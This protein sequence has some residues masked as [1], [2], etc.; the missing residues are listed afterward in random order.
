M[1]ASRPNTHTLMLTHAS[2]RT[3][4]SS[5]PPLVSDV[6]IWDGRL[7]LRCV[8]APHLFNGFESN[9]QPSCWRTNCAAVPLNRQCQEGC[10]ASFCQAISLYIPLRMLFITPTEALKNL[11]LVASHGN[12]GGP[13]PSRI[14]AVSAH[15]Q[16]ASDICR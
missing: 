9:L 8:H 2:M 4:R 16:L 5:S 6:T 3:R 13:R 12:T 7:R 1:H 15:D 14:M 10:R 11:A